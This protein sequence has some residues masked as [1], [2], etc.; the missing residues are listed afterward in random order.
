MLNSGCTGWEPNPCCYSVSDAIT[1]PWKPLQFCADETTYDTQPAFAI[2]LGGED[3]TVL[4]MGDRWSGGEYF[5]SSYVLLPLKF[6][7]EDELDFAYHDRFTLDV[8]AG[9]YISVEEERT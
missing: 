7:G 1:G 6:F 4:Y 5:S 8:Q 3:G 9:K 2:P